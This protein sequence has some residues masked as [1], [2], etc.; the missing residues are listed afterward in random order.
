MS[1][2]AIW[3]KK[4]QIFTKR[5]TFQSTLIAKFVF[6]FL[7]PKLN[8][9]NE[10]LYEN[11]KTHNDECAKVM[12]VNASVHYTKFV[13]LEGSTV[14]I[15]EDLDNNQ[16]ARKQKFKPLFQKPRLLKNV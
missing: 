11:V 2:R 1:F 15:K 5:K 9:E 3:I 13:A 14:W 16:S 8:L 12:I 4:F 7:I 6:S 10:K